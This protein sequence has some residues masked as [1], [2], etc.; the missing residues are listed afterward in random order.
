MF[1]SEYI[2][3]KEVQKKYQIT[4]TT[5]K[6]YVSQ[7]LL[8]ARQLPGGKHLYLASSIEK[9]LGDYDEE[10]KHEEKKKICYARVSSKKQE[11][12]LDRQ[13]ADLQE[14]YPDHEL[15]KDIGS[16]VNFKRRGF[17]KMLDQVLE[18]KVQQIVIMHKDRMCRFGF[19]LV[20][21]ICKKCGTEI[22]IHTKK[23]GTE[24]DD[25]AELSEDLLSIITIFTAR[26]HGIRSAENKKRRR[27]EKQK[28]KSKSKKRKQKKLIDETE[29]TSDQQ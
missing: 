8:K 2:T 10:E 20:E 6:R 3:L 11:T 23:S 28:D 24:K 4:G 29:N 26:S 5:L 9:L 16:G 27:E 14:Q 7:G 17:T 22:I 15:I 25:S 13:V 18:G 19:E 12:D 1:N 21:Q